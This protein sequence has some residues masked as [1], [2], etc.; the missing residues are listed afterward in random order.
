[1]ASQTGTDAQKEFL[2]Q[3]SLSPSGLDILQ[4]YLHYHGPVHRT[5]RETRACQHVRY[6][7]LTYS[8]HPVHSNQSAPSHVV[9]IH[10][11]LAQLGRP[12]YDQR[13]VSLRYQRVHNPLRTFSILEPRRP[14]SCQVGKGD[15]AT[16][17]ET[18][19]TR[20]CIVAANAGF[21]NTHTGAC[22]GNIVCDGKLVQDSGGIQNVHF[23][24]TIDGHLFTGYLSEIELVTHNFQ[25]LVGGVIW[26]IRDGEIYVDESRDIEC[27]TTEETGTLE[28]FI[29]V[30]SARTAVG[31][32]SEGHILMAQ[33]DGKTN[34]NGGNL[35]EF[36]SLLKDLGFV[37]AINLDGGGSATSVINGT[38]VNYPSDTCDDNQWNCAREVSTILCVHKIE[39]VPGDCSGHGQCVA[40]QCQCQGFWSGAACNSLQC[41][42]QCSNHGLCFEDG[43]VC[44]AGWTGE[45]CDIACAN[46]TFGL[47]CA[48]ICSCM[49][50]AACDP[51]SGH[52]QC[53]PGYRGTLCD[54]ACP[55]GFYGP[56][57]ASECSC[58]DTCFCDH[59]TG[60]CNTT[61]FQA[62]YLQAGECLLQVRVKRDKLVPD[63]SREIVH[64]TWATISLAVV[65]S[66]N[67][68]L[69][70][71]LAALVL[72]MRHKPSDCLKRRPQ[73][74]H[75][76]QRLAMYKIPRKTSHHSPRYSAHNS[77]DSLDSS[78]EETA[79]VDPHED[80]S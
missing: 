3:S 66:L 58:P 63:Q 35:R 54:S 80:P 50:G 29:S 53:P 64:W 49:N 55:Y 77:K 10:H 67:F 30:E 71:W 13:L 21:F 68:V 59:V 20:N 61:S 44:D 65:A 14:G 16:V 6:G 19:A 52:C 45:D 32:D 17:Q 31:H 25:H 69:N 78:D 76:K 34:Q 38:V 70:I 5:L 48:G 4:P 43:C 2:P 41:P 24:V 15:R 73:I 37:N 60:V 47:Q 22:L 26:L 57:C 23:G 74:R 36:A 1:M 33:L 42:G 51:T 7:N 8:L 11:K 27:S 18:A 75:S 72:K 62:D 46:G 12:Y 39:C 9:D 40:G 56:R 79:L 28:T